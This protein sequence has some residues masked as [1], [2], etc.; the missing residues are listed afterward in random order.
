[1]SQDNKYRKE[2]PPHYFHIS[3]ISRQEEKDGYYF[4]REVFRSIQSRKFPKF[5]HFKGLLSNISWIIRMIVWRYYHKRLLRPDNAIAPLNIVL[6]QSVDDRNR[7]T[8]DSNNEDAFGNSCPKIEWRVTD[9]DCKNL[10]SVCENFKSVWD[11]S[12]LAKLGELV[13]KDKALLCKEIGQSTGIYHP[14][15]STAFGTSEDFVVDRNMYLRGNKNIQVLSTSVLPTGGGA[16]PTMMAL[17]IAFRCIHQHAN[18]DKKRNE[19]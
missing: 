15:S 12:R 11:N 1:M 14:T 9:E 7:I 6:E 19:T 4:L 5:N 2:L 8:L 16:N 17:L 10:V 3:F 18:H 13:L